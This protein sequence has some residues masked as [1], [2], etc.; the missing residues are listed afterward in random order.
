MISSKGS[1]GM[2][3][4]TMSSLRRVRQVDGRTILRIF[5][6]KGSRNQLEGNDTRGTGAACAGGEGA[7]GEGD[8]GAVLAGFLGLGGSIPAKGGERAVRNI[9]NWRM[10]NEELARNRIDSG[11]I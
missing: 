7:A 3:I 11:V 10:G 2:D 1:L 5:A 4:S 9:R 6:Q 8:G